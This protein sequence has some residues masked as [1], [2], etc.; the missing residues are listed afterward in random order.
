[1]KMRPIHGSGPSAIVTLDRALNAAILNGDVGSGYEEYLAIFDSF[2]ADDL[3]AGSDAFPGQIV[4]KDGLRSILFNFLLPLHTMG[5]VGG[6]NVSIKQVPVPTDERDATCSEWTLELSGVTGARC[7][8]SWC[9]IRKWK[10]GRVV[11][12]WHLD[13][14][15]V[16]GPLGIADLHFGPE[17]LDE[18]LTKPS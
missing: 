11:S 6:L 3:Q 7:T 17:R 1:M 9:S 12:E 10:D 5:E 15:Q 16:G 13:H 18:G 4:G 2:Y 14:R 8:L